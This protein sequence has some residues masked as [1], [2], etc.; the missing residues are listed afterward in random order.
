MLMVIGMLVVIVGVV[1]GWWTIEGSG[2]HERPYSG[3]DAPGASHQH[4]ESPLDS[5]W[6]MHDWGRG[7]Q[8]RAGRRRR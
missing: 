5:P 8:T 7:T 2:I 3:G 6:E 4:G 1:I